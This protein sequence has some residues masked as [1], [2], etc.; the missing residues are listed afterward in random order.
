V[1]EHALDQG[2]EL[3]FLAAS[4]EQATVHPLAR[5][6]RDSATRPLVEPTEVEVR[7]GA[8]LSGRVGGRRVAVGTLAYLRALRVDLTLAKVAA[9]AYSAIGLTPVFVAVDGVCRGALGIEDAMRPD[10]PAAL[11]ALTRDQITLVVASGDRRSAVDRLARTAGLSDA[12]YAEQ[13]PGE[14]AALVDRLRANGAV[15]FAGDGANDAPALAAADLAIAI[16]EGADLAAEQADVVIPG[17]RLGAI[18]ELLHVARRTKHAVRRNL[19]WA[20]GY[21][22]LLLPIAAGAIP[23]V[24]I[25]M[26]IAAAAMAGS[27]IGVA[28]LSLR[29]RRG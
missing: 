12:L 7:P 25:T 21:N 15:A 27:S 4:L 17:A 22:T 1:F 24:E 29:L 16:G 20:F 14:K 18:A 10:A 3:L 9:D 26:P 13:S 19:V 8:G 6:I 28:L 23:G 5:A 2:D 11:T